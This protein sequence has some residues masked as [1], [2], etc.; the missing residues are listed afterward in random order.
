MD[1]ET[2]KELQA[3]KQRNLRVEAD[4]AWETSKTRRAL[5]ALTTYILA[6]ILFIMLNAPNPFLTA[7][8]P[9]V[10]YLLST[11]SMPFLKDWWL[12]RIYRK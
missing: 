3:I 8:V 10:A 4:K 5:V 2:R 1:A 12:E 9:A 6:A 7:L 11:L